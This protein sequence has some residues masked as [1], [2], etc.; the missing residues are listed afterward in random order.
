MPAATAG[1]VTSFA[2]TTTCIAEVSAGNASLTRLKVCTTASSCG[3]E[4]ASAGWPS[5]IWVAGIARA[6]I[7]AVASPADS[8]GRR[9]TRSMI[10]DQIPMRATR[11]LIRVRPGMWLRPRRCPTRESTAGSTVSD[12]SIATAT[13]RIE[14]VAN[15]VKTEESARYMPAMAVMT[16]R[17]DT[18]TACPEVAAA[19]SSAASLS[20]PA[21][22][23]SFIRRT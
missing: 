15:E 3:S 23:S 9:R 19:A 22:S 18:S 21:A 10:L 17:P 6:T 2:L 1:A 20:R 12:P 7:T 8:Q 16:V 5:S 4:S 11:A 14:P 13:T